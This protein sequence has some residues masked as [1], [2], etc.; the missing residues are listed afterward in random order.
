MTPRRLRRQTP[1]FQASVGGLV[2]LAVLVL[3]RV[4]WWGQWEYSAQPLMALG[5]FVLVAELAALWGMLLV[6]RSIAIATLEAHREAAG[7]VYATLGAAYAVLLSFM[8]V[9]SWTQYHDAEQ[10]I[11]NEAL[12]TVTLFHLADGLD[13]AT[14]RDLQ[15]ALV[16]YTQT[17]V[18]DEWP[19]MA[20]GSESGRAWELSDHLWD[21][22]MHAPADTQARP[23]YTQ[24]LGQM[25]QFY[26]L[27]GRRLLES[28]SALPSAVW[29]VLAAGAAVTVGF[30]Y[31]FGVHRLLAQAVITAALTAIIAGSLYLI[32]DFDTLYTGPLQMDRAPLEANLT[33]FASRS[34]P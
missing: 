9:V 3:L 21:A 17:V 2:L 22:Y 24:A 25:Q 30:T 26:A 6:R 10:T 23:A 14:R 27:R 13:D 33:F 5:S 28:R 1:L 32:V 34:Q 4:L 15:Q 7:Y 19:A 29:V 20:R 16:A 12:A 18:D 31:L 11:T 8:V